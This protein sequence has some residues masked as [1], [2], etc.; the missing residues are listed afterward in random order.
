MFVTNDANFI[1]NF[2]IQIA[3][4]IFFFFINQKRFGGMKCIFGIGYLNQKGP[5]WGF[6]PYFQDFLRNKC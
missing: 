2:A 3:M 5:E 4:Q 6:C 1:F